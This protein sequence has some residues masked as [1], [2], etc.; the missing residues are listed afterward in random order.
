VAIGAE[1][2]ALIN[3]TDLFATVAE[4]AGVDLPTTL[5]TTT[6]DSVSTVPYFS[7]P[8]LESVRQTNLAEIFL[9][10][11]PTGGLPIPAPDPFVC[12]QDL[13][14]AGPGIVS[15]SLCGEVLAQGLSADLQLTGGPPGAPAWLI[16]GLNFDPTPVSGGMLTPFPW[17]ALVAMA[18]DGVGQINIPNITNTVDF[19]VTI[20]F[21]FAVFNPALPEWYAFSNTVAANLEPPHRKAIRDLQYKLIVNYFGAPDQFYDLD[22]DPLE[23][24]DLLSL[25]PLTPTEDAAYQAL[26]LAL[27]DLLATP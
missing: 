13:G 23:E 3:T 6:L 5:P 24:H 12:Q 10:N 26:Q 9:P 4:L 15:L 25:G 17:L 22:D 11:S 27:S 7:N 21:Q 1:C 2:D 18:T 20:Y 19:P 14:F 8:A 16:L